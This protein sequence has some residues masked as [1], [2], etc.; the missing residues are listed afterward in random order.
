MKK[1]RGLKFAANSKTKVF[2]E[3]VLPAN[4]F[5]LKKTV[6]NTF[7]M[8]VANKSTAA[9]TD[10]PTNASFGLMENAGGEI[11]VPICTRR[12]TLDVLKRMMIMKK[13]LTK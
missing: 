9:P 2:A 6:K 4:I 12:K 3:K 10:T 7:L 1:I 11:A 5:I 8:D 13:L